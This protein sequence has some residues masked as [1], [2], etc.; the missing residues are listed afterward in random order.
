MA[1]VVEEV[2]PEIKLFFCFLYGLQSMA[3]T[4]DSE[5]TDGRDIAME[6]GVRVCRR[7]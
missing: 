7:E 6:G 4:C 2:C 1:L 3:S 5:E